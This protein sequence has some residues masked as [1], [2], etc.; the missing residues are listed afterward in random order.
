[1]KRLLIIP[2]AIFTIIIIASFANANDNERSFN[3][4]TICIKFEPEK[5]K[6]IQLEK[7][8]KAVLLL[9]K[10]KIQ[11]IILAGENR[12]NMELKKVEVP[13]ANFSEYEII[14]K[15]DSKKV[16]LKFLDNKCV[17]TSGAGLNDWESIVWFLVETNFLKFR[18]VLNPGSSIKRIN[19]YENCP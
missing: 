11:G 9:I 17:I 8:D 6:E 3:F 1:M 4:V 16:N 10:E 5:Y 2:M 13:F 19:I 18:L 14:R 7:G 12:E 15:S